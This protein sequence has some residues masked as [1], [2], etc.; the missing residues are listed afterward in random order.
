MPRR[1]NPQVLSGAQCSRCPEVFSYLWA[2][3][4][5]LRQFCDACTRANGQNRYDFESL[6]N[7]PEI[8]ESGP[9]LIYVISVIHM[10]GLVKIGSCSQQSVESRVYKMGLPNPVI[11]ASWTEAPPWRLERYLHAHFRQYRVKGTE[12]FLLE[13]KKVIDFVETLKK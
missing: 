8:V 13:G 4:G 9:K 5:R 11:E 12:W 1:F 6:N 10:P 3:T 2:G 7:V